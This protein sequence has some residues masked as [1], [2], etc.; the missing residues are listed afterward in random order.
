MAGR[1]AQ[2]DM[3]GM[4]VHLQAGLRS[5]ARGGV[6]QHLDALR[7]ALHAQGVVLTRGAP[8]LHVN[9]SLRWRALLR[10]LTRTQLALL[11]GRRVLWHLHG[12]S[13]ALA[14]GLGRVSLQGRVPAR[15]R[16]VTLTEH[17]RRQL[18]SWG[19]PV[20]QTAVVGP[21]A[22]S[23]A[24]PPRDAAGPLLFLGRLV[25]GKGVHRL[26]EA[27]GSRRVVIA[28]EGAERA[29]LEALAAR[30]P[31][32]AR[33]VG[34][35]PDVEPLLAE[36]SALVLPSDDEGLPVC[37]LEALGSGR[38]VV[39]TAVGGLPEL[40]GDR[41]VPPGDTPALAAALERVDDVPP[42]LQAEIRA[43]YA[44]QAVAKQLLAVYTELMEVP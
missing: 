13:E 31:V 41:L 9:P 5:G 8:L 32:R 11:R 19:V 35:V 14:A 17:R 39:A 36:C 38:P 37:V 18:V 28:G 16:V 29:R 40:L 12:W 15:M 7:P 25:A 42:S 24:L 20:E 6:A 10:D 34:W 43:R 3:V 26:L 44:P 22:R 27:A 2:S 33:F 23:F 30:L 21:C 1:I 4:H